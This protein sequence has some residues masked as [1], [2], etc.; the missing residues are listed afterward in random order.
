MLSRKIND[1]KDEII[2]EDNSELDIHGKDKKINE[3]KKSKI[4]ESRMHNFALDTTS[5]N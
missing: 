4:V 2:M 3:E 1:G 5:S